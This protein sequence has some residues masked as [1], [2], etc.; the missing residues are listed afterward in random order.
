M[1]N[2]LLSHSKEK[3]FLPLFFSG[4]FLIIWRM[5]AKRNKRL[6][7]CYHVGEK[8]SL[9]GKDES[10][11]SGKHGKSLTLRWLSKAEI[12]LKAKFSSELQFQMT[13]AICSIA[14]DGD[15]W[16]YWISFEQRLQA[17]SFITEFLSFYPWKMWDWC[18]F[19]CAHWTCFC[20]IVIEQCFS[21]SWWTCSILIW[22]CCYSCDASSDSLWH[23]P[24]HIGNVLCFLNSIG[25][26][27]WSYQ[28]R[29]LKK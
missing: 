27:H 25:S 15:L 4:N 28:L 14:I 24:A 11:W 17:S 16:L 10:T 12:K 5:R 1:K 6:H 23:D 9:H 13:T 18:Q 2:F 19:I 7:N 21:L 26:E 22:I 20:R 3:T 8:F 29:F